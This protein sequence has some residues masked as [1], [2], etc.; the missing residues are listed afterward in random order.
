MNIPL[1]WYLGSTALF[2]IPAGIQIVLYPWLV[3]VYLDETATRVG[4]A[5]SAAQVPTLLLIL[6]GGWLGD[7]VDQRRLLM[8]LTALMSLVPL[9]VA[10]VFLSGAFNYWILLAWALV[11]GT[12]AAFVQPARDALLNRVAGADIQRVVVLSI[13]IQFGVQIVGFAIGSSADWL[14]PPSLLFAMAFFMLASAWAVSRVPIAPPGTVKHTQGPLAGIAQGVKAAM[15]H[16]HIRPAIIQTFSVGVFFAG[17]YMVLLPLIIR[18]IY[19]GGSAHIAGTFAANMF[20]TVVIT[21]LMM[22][23]GRTH[24]PGRLLICA[25]SVS[26]STLFWL[27]FDMPLWAFYTVVFCWGACGGIGMSMS[28]TIVQEAAQPELRARIMSIYSLGLI[29]G[30]PIGSFLLGVLSDVVG[31]RNAV[32]FPVIGML[33]VIAYLALRTQL[34]HVRSEVKLAGA[35]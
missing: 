11:G 16:P 17:A 12:F 24:R 35:E 3:A 22:R 20:G 29:G 31:V 26:A 27:W 34:W 32:L 5:Q 25:G 10:W 14:G 21:F 33:L 30:M 19:D 28:R 15:R 23:R 9:T 13:G 6:F 8:V 4:I 1:A 18:D 2:L 7:R